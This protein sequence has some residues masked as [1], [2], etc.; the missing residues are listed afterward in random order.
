MQSHNQGDALCPCNVDTTRGLT[1]GTQLYDVAQEPCEPES[2]QTKAKRELSLRRSAAIARQLV[3]SKEVQ[4]SARELCESET[5][6]GSDFVSVPNKLFC[7]MGTVFRSCCE[8][9]AR[10]R[11]C[12]QRYWKPWVL[13]GN[14][15]GMMGSWLESWRRL[16]VF[17]E[18]LVH[19]LTECIIVCHRYVQSHLFRSTM[20]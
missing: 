4:H 15:A 14:R 16:V 5:S 2:K 10:Y 12:R 18:V 19:C 13:K 11:R 20:S 7:D 6:H 8:A 3:V 9:A 1:N 17:T